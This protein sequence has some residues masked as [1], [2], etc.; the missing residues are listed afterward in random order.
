M[1]V[2]L[3]A[4]VA[5]GKAILFDTLDPDCFWHLKVA[6]QLRTDGIGPLTD[7]LSFAS[8]RE[9]WTPYSWLAELWMKGIWDAGGYRLAVLAHAA[10]SASFVVLLALTARAS[11]RTAVIVSVVF[12][13]FLSLPYLSFRPATFAIVLLA[14]GHLILRSDLENRSQRVFLL[15]PLTAALANVHLFALLVPIWVGAVAVGRHLERRYVLLLA[16]TALAACAT[17]MLPGLLKTIL[18]YQFAD[19]MVAGPVIAEMQPFWSGP[20]GKVSLGLV[21]AALACVYRN[22]D[23]VTPADWVLLAGSVA[24]LY[25]H[26]RYAPLFAIVA[27]PLLAQ[28]LT[29]LSD[30]VLA[31]PIL[32]PVLAVMLVAV[33]ARLGVALPSRDTPIDAWLNRHGSDAPGYPSAAT[34]FVATHALRRSGRLI[35]EFTWGGYIAWRLGPQDFQVLL[36][37][38]TQVYSPNFW[39]ATYLGPAERLPSFLNVQRADAAIVPVRNSRFKGALVSLGWDVAF[40]DERAEVLVPP[41]THAALS[42]D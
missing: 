32:R 17:P 28:S 7:H 13:I 1:L 20:A 2:A 26:G 29:G 3:L 15:V 34:D 39:R 9:P 18:H 25:L 21:L 4:L 40:A 16:A 41:S 5:G 42:R 10:L 38:R 30:S 11:G 37:G 35:T 12:S 31:K 36:D 24:L 6:E 33:V 8:S 14:L 22:R 23:N 19:P 27:T